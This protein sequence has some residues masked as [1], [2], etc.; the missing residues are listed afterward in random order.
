MDLLLLLLEL[1]T[2]FTP[3]DNNKNGLSLQPFPPKKEMGQNRCNIGY[4][5]NG[6]PDWYRNV[7]E[8]HP[9]IFMVY[10]SL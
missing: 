6:S 3:I 8:H 2:D 1:L 10:N 4:M 9:N 7:Y 5:K